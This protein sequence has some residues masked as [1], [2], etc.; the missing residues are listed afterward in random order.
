[1]QANAK[2]VYLFKLGNTIRARMKFD[3]D[4]DTMFYHLGKPNYNATNH[5]RIKFTVFESFSLIEYLRDILNQYYLHIKHSTTSSHLLPFFNGDTTRCKEE[6]KDKVARLEYWTT[7]DMALKS[8]R[9]RLSRNELT[10]K[11]TVHLNA[12]IPYEVSKRLDI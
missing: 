10:G 12:N 7:P 5:S 2:C 8:I 6:P 11:Y 4:L 9:C 3:Q 1:M